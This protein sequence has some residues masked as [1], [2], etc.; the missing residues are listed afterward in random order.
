[1][2][3]NGRSK[4]KDFAHHYLDALIALLRRIDE[5]ESEAIRK[6]AV[7]L[8]DAIEGKPG[9]SASAVL[10]L[11]YPFRTWSTGPEAWH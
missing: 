4:M 6:G 7:L 1:M 11:P 2:P 10:I 8:A 3:Q 5:E 9:Y